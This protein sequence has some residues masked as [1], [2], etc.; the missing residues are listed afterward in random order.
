MKPPFIDERDAQINGAVAFLCLMLTQLGLAGVILY[1]RYVLG[2][3]PEAYAEL[4]WI[5]GL[6]LGA[7]WLVRLY[8]RGVLPVPSVRAALAIYGFAVLII[9]VPTYFIHGWPAPARWFEV[10]YP[11]V[12]V[13][14]VLALYTLVA[15]LGKRR[16]DQ[17]AE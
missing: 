2:L 15:Y 14:V 7:Y 5:L 4:T 10:L 12:G 9:S 17:L 1:K 16:I 11:V 3:P 6:S 13:A 8:L